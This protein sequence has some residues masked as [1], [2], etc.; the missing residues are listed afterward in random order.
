MSEGYL[1]KEDY[2]KLKSRRN[3]MGLAGA[4]LNVIDPPTHDLHEVTPERIKM[5]AE[6]L[7]ANADKMFG[8]SAAIEK[9]PLSETLHPSTYLEIMKLAYQAQANFFQRGIVELYKQRAEIQRFLDEKMQVVR[10][11][12]DIMNTLARTQKLLPNNTTSET[13]KTIEELEDFLDS[14]IFV[15]V[16]E[17]DKY[18]LYRKEEIQDAIDTDTVD[19]V[20]VVRVESV[21]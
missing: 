19:I 5:D 4:I 2:E 21:K 1:S 17:E 11:L 18:Q 8:E 16:N 9:P 13:V 6:T 3:K 12:N 7:W 10:E 14:D 20:T 15:C